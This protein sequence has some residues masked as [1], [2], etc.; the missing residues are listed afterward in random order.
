MEEPA[1]HSRPCPAPCSESRDRTRLMASR[2]HSGSQALPYRSEVKT[3][4]RAPRLSDAWQDPGML[5][6]LAASTAAWKLS[7]APGSVCGGM[8]GRK[9][10]VGGPTVC[11]PMGMWPP[12]DEAPPGQHRTA[13]PRSERSSTSPWL[14]EVSPARAWTSRVAP[15]TIMKRKEIMVRV[16]HSTSTTR[17]PPRRALQREDRDGLDPLMPRFGGAPA[18]TLAVLD[19]SGVGPSESAVAHAKR[20]PRPLHS[21]LCIGGMQP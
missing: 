15:G 20:S 8:G 4:G 21:K 13:R 19:R 1:P 5:R 2:V 10:Q 17:I 14:D 18:S 9:G 6:S 11:Y 12:H 16:A 7:S 3:T